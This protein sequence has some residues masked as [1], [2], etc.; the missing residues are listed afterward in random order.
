VHRLLLLS[1]PFQLRGRAPPRLLGL[2]RFHIRGDP[3]VE[4]CV[5]PVGRGREVTEPLVRQLVRHQAAP[6]VRVGARTVEREVGL[7]RRRHVLHAAVREVGDGRLVVLVP[8]IR[9]TEEARVQ[10]DHGGRLAEQAPSGVHR[11]R[12]HP[13]V[14]RHVAPMVVQHGERPHHHRVEIGGRGLVLRPV[15]D[16]LSTAARRRD[17]HQLAVRQHLEPGIRGDQEVPGGLVVRVVVGR[18]PRARLGGFALRP[19]D[20]A[21]RHEVDPALGVGVVRQREDHRVPSRGP[22][23]QAHGDVRRVSGEPEGSPASVGRP[24][25]RHVLRIEPDRVGGGR[26]DHGRRHLA[27]HPPLRFVEPDRDGLMHEV[28]V[29]R[30]LRPSA[31]RHV[32]ADDPGRALGPKGGSRNGH[33]HGSNGQE[34]TIHR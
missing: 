8:R 23:G 17:I 28:V 13:V 7:R 20:V 21:P 25:D 34:M 29:V 1:P 22:S 3:L 33:E 32:L 19:Q 9:H 16:A 15:P 10:L 14:H 2:H 27:R 11:V 4:P 31:R 5:G 26:R 12:V 24:V 30:R 18:D 6:R